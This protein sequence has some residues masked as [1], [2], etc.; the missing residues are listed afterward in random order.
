M[1]RSQVILIIAIIVLAA[2]PIVTCSFYNC[3]TILYPAVRDAL[4]TELHIAAPVFSAVF[5]FVALVV[6]G[7]QTWILHRQS[8]IQRTQS[9][10]QERQ[11][12]LSEA[13]S[14]SG[15]PFFHM[16]KNRLIVNFKNEG[17]GTA[18][19]TTVRYFLKEKSSRKSVSGSISLQPLGSQSKADIEVTS[20]DVQILLREY[21]TLLLTWQGKCADGHEFSGG[22]R[23]EVKLSELKMVAR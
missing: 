10:I 1:N 9:D 15:E 12:R 8:K 19:S 6:L 21:E 7:V 20:E 13:V 23:E 18:E 16:Q 5:S 22:Y 11:L 14:L 4:G 3:L 2:V 17:K